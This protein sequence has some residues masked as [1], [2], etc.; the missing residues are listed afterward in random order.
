MKSKYLAYCYYEEAT[1]EW[2]NYCPECYK[3]LNIRAGLG[4]SDAM[5]TDL[6]G[7]VMKCGICSRGIK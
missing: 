4:E 6:N 7:D 5:M 3:R 2:F 1:K